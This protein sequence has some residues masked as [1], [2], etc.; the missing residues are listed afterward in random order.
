MENIE[1]MLDLPYPPEP[2]RAMIA[3]D[4]GSRCGAERQLAATLWGGSR[5][6]WSLWGMISFGV[7]EIVWL[8]R[9]CGRLANVLGGLHD[10]LNQFRSEEQKKIDAGIFGA[11]GSAFAHIGLQMCALHASRIKEQCE[12]NTALTHQ[13]MAGMVHELIN[14]I[15]DECS[16]IWFLQFT[17]DETRLINPN[18]P[19]FGNEIEDKIPSLSEDISE[20]GKCLGFSRSTAAV[21]HLM[22]VMESSV[23]KLGDILGIPLVDEKNWQTILDQINKKV[24]AMGTTP[25]AKQYASISAH[26]YNVKLAWRNET[27]H[28]KSTYTAEEASA[29]FA[30][31]RGYMK[32]FIQVL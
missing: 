3:P 24:K 1:A 28:P 22:R 12:T 15:E 32:E 19:L 25:Q 7:S 4:A 23:Q 31:V 21:F 8:S 18:A 9:E 20:A 10:D 13:D 17:G 16:K 30:A 27:M 2:G 26:L 11:W 6:L 29:I 5:R 14:R